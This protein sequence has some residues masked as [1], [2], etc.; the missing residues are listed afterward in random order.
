MLFTSW[1]H[2]LRVIV[3]GILAYVGLVV[4]LRISGKRTLSS[5][6][7]FDMVVTVALGSTLASTILPQNT[8][9]IDGIFALA[10]LVGMQF[11]TARLV[12]YSTTFSRW[13]KSEPTLLLHKGKM[14]KEAM[15]RERLEE[16]EV[17]AA[18][19]KNGLLDVTKVEA[20]ILE[21]DGSISVIP[22]SVAAETIKLSSI[23]G[24]ANRPLADSSAS[25]AD[26]E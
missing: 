24:V 18:V 14:L 7:I 25:A 17:L 13:V 4:L 26:A 5:M 6:N 9:L 15:H 20:V 10:V 21:T 16:G 3:V 22:E 12:V 8:S 2:L 11:V 19:R 23:Q 1:D